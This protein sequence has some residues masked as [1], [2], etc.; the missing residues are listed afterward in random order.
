MV[1]LSQLAM[2]AI[3]ARTFEPGLFA[4]WTV[5]L[6]LAALT[7]LFSANLASVVTRTLVTHEQQA[8]HAPAIL[9]AAKGLSR[10]LGLLALVCIGLLVVAIRPWS[11][12]L[13]QM[14][15]GTLAATALALTI[16][17][18]WQ[19]GLQPAIGWHFAREHAW[20]VAA[21]TTFIR[22]ASL[23]GLLAAWA[24]QETS[25]A[26]AGTML[27]G[28]AWLAVAVVWRLGFSPRPEAG[29]DAGLAQEHGTAIL[30]LTKAFAVWSAGSAAIQYGLPAAMSILAG[31]R[32]NGFFLAYT[33]N[34]VTLGVL[35]S[36]ATALM[37]PTARMVTAGRQASIDRALFWGPVLTAVAVLVMLL[38]VQ[39]ATPL[40]LPA[41]APGVA[42]AADV[43]HFIG[44]LGFQAI[45]RS[46]AL[47]FSVVLSAAG[48]PRQV[49]MPIGLEILVV[50][51]LAAPAGAWWGGDAFLIAL[52]VAG[53]LAALLVARL[54]LQAIGLTR[55]Q[56]L[57]VLA[58]FMVIEAGAL[59]VWAALG[60]GA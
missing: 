17:Q 35:G 8:G 14:A 6:S 48:T 4:P 55:A 54:T 60:H 53:V 31:A 33:L 20:T 37:A 13:Q 44:L 59:S 32:Y 24:L 38:V 39:A 27:C 5:L 47:M 26:L 58:R 2:T 25:P 57:R 46:L 9:Q 7:P 21:A 23:A 15:T 42:S 43:T 19:I 11:L 22:L 30:Q 51:G 10:R 18:L 56:T 41:L 36:V 1:A 40:L 3:A 34:L 29:V 16:A 45:A 50:V 12:P 52:A 49:A 28:A